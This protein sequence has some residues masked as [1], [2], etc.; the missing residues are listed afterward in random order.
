MTAAGNYTVTVTNPNN[1]CFST[2]TAATVFRNT[3]VPGAVSASVSDR[4]S[5]NNTPV[6]LTGNS[7]TIGHAASLGG[8]A[9]NTGATGFSYRLYPNPASTTVY[10]DLRSPVDAQVTVEVYNS[11]GIREKILFDGIMQAGIPYQWS[12]DASRLTSGVH[13]CLIRTNNKVYTAKLLSL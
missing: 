11:V 2:V 1:G 3:T 13:Y 12:L 8:T 7:T 4:L 9:G 5:C 6:T 10:V